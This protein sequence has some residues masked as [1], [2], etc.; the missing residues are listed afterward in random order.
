MSVV[1]RSFIPNEG[2]ESMTTARA[3]HTPYS[4][5]SSLDRA[6]LR[7][8]L[9]LVT[10]SRRARTDASDVELHEVRRA[11]Q[12]ALEERNAAH[13]RALLLLNR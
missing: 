8:G 10:W 9:A 5:Y 6:M 12:R 4:S 3:I 7:L 11:Q 1:P 13:V 2:N